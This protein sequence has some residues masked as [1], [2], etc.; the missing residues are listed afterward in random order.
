MQS[1]PQHRWHACYGT[2]HTYRGARA[3]PSVSDAHPRDPSVAVAMRWH[4]QGI[5]AVSVVL[6]GGYPTTLAAHRHRAASRTLCVCQPRNDFFRLLRPPPDLYHNIS[7]A[8][9]SQPKPGD[10]LLVLADG[11]PTQPTIIS[12]VQYAAIA[13]AGVRVFV[14]FPAALPASSALNLSSSMPQ[15]LD[16]ACGISAEP[17]HNGGVGLGSSSISRVVIAT[18][19]TM[20]H[21]LAPMRILGIHGSVVMP[22]TLG[23][24]QSCLPWPADKPRTVN[25]SVQV[26]LPTHLS[27]LCARPTEQPPSHVEYVGM[28][29]CTAVA[30][31]W[32]KFIVNDVRPG[33]KS[34]PRSFTCAASP[35]FCGQ[36]G[37]KSPKVPNLPSHLCS[38]SNNGS[39]AGTTTPVIAVA[40]RV[41]GY[42]HAVFGLPADGV[43][44]ILFEATDSALIAT[45]SF[46]NVLQGR[47]GPVRAWGSLLRFVLAWIGST[48]T[49]SPLVP[50]V[51]PAYSQHEALT[52]LVAA[53]RKALE[54]AVAH[55]VDTSGLLYSS[56]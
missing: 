17:S 18:N 52:S 43:A 23:T 4:W 22:T 35:E 20:G 10:A 48:L 24:V 36:C 39:R 53:E 12:P 5:L 31:M 32:H 6:L 51:R 3:R 49:L 28:V 42:D 2:I 33:A 26:V 13:A 29:C 7:A 45:T 27:A 50:R 44:A 21:G 1:H 9:A 47:Y 38:A 8:L 25:T 34:K 37:G 14:E 55:L 46:S 11:Y 19:A 54:G 30:I 16:Q 41:A 15:A 40:A 56:L